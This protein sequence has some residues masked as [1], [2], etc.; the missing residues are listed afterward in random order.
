MTLNRRFG[1]L[2][3]KSTAI[4][5]SFWCASPEPDAL[6]LSHLNLNVYGLGVSYE[7]QINP[8]S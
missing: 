1:I 8:L 3:M 5:S 2:N 6:V 7:L 4:I